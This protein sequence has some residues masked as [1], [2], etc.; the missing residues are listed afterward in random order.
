M[1]CHRHVAVLINTVHLN[2]NKQN[3]I[4]YNPDFSEHNIGQF[5]PTSNET[6]LLMHQSYNEDSKIN[7]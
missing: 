5:S 4:K 6:V 7:K 3:K 2:I 1:M